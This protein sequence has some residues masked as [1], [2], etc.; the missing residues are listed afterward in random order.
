MAKFEVKSARG[1][2]SDYEDKGIAGS[3]KFAKNID[4]RKKIDSISCGQAFTEEGLTSTGSSASASVSPSSSASDSASRSAS[5]SISPTP[6]PSPSASPSASVSPS[7]SRSPSYSVS[8]SPSV[9]SAITSVFRG[10]I[11]TFVKASD[12]FTYGFDDLGYIY[13]RDSERKW[14]RVYKDENG[15]ITG[16]CEKPSSTG[17]TYLVWAT[18]R[19]VKK[20][21]IPGRADWNDAVVAGTA[22]LESALW[23]TMLQA[24][25]SAYIC[26]GPYIALVGYDESY[27][28]EAL[29]LIPGNV[30]NT[31]VERDGRVN[32]GAARAAEP[33]KGVNAAIDVEVPLSQIGTD[34]AL[35]FAN[36]ADS[37][38]MKRF[39]GGGRVNPGGVCAEVEEVNFFE[40]EQT[41]L[42]WID[43]QTVGNLAFFAVFGAESGKN[44]V[45]S[46]GRRD[47]NH[48]FVMNLEYAIEATE[49]GA[50]ACVNGEVLVS[51]RSG[52]DV[53]V[54][55][56][57]ASSKATGTWEGLDLRAPSKNP[58]EST[59]WDTA[60]VYMKPLP[61]GCSVEFWYRMNKKDNF[62]QAKTVD[63]S[64]AATTTGVQKAQFRIN[65]KGD[66][67]EPKLVL[68]VSGNSTPEIYRQ[69]YY[70]H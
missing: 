69:L 38:P 67:F 11:R 5:A 53:G 43:K 24:G 55:R 37:L 28:N 70:F 36:M 27:T 19:V 41:A 1:G 14:V 7:A 8:P 12:G 20:K 2:L 23:H 57:D 9:S 15:G 46:V 21:E 56:V 39:P 22:Q 26:N 18:N 49:L 3:F 29:D 61:V 34:G 54:K 45:Y 48:P 65:G 52:S 50:I 44:G 58:D 47:K 10:L 68:N 40:W 30:A 62:V 6:S 17:K 42:S 32:I 16:A 60:E 13:R 35:Y 25:G 59:I 63:G 31:L 4:I 64:A 51:Y 66:I 33:T